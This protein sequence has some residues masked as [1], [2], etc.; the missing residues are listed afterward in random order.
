MGQ[1]IGALLFLVVWFSIPFDIPAWVGAAFKT[2]TLWIFSMLA[3][4]NQSSP[5]ILDFRIRA[6]HSVQSCQFL[7]LQVSIADD[8]ETRAGGTLRRFIDIDDGRVVS[9]SVR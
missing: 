7:K 8:N 3:P 4:W 2:A 6:S 1:C 9:G 5:R